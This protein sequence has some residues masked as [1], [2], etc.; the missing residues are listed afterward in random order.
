MHY[1]ITNEN[2]A[3][4]KNV[5]NGIFC[6]KQ[7][8]Q[9]DTSKLGDVVQVDWSERKFRSERNVS[10]LLECECVKLGI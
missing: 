8:D 1:K 6:I 4:P 10:E 3:Q 2:K 5:I 9:E 7:S